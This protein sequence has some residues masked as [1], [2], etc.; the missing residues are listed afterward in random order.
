[1]RDIRLI[2][3]KK[4]PRGTKTRRRADDLTPVYQCVVGTSSA[5][6]A[7]SR[8]STYVEC[9]WELRTGTVRGRYARRTCCPVARLERGMPA[10]GAR[11]R[12]REQPEE[13]ISGKAEEKKEQRLRPSVR[14]AGRVVRASASCVCR[15]GPAPEIPVAVITHEQSSKAHVIKRKQIR[16]RRRR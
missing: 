4:G 1:V 5:R 15:R 14:C 3:N 11:R 2:K 9:V 16:R 13:K 10:D 6:P 7:T 12:V 8:V